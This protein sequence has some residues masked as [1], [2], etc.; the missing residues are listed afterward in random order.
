MA[1]LRLTETNRL[2]AFS[3]GVFAIALTLLVLELKVPDVHDFLRELPR[4]GVGYAAYFAS[5][6]TIAS[7]WSNHHDTFSRVGR[8][9]ARLLVLNLALLLG[10]SLV[11][12][13]TSL[14]ATAMRGGDRVDEIIAILIYGLVSLYVSI[15]WAVIGTLLTRNPAL[16]ND[17]RDLASARLHRRRATLAIIPILVAIGIAFLAPLV[18]LAIYLLVPLAFFAFLWWQDEPDDTSGGP[19]ADRATGTSV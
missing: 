13:P 6:L 19:V 14:V 9:D 4:D 8:S 11:P 2:E 7:I 12:W 10:V 16:L 5:F 1:R 17:P 3:D 15:V 18:S